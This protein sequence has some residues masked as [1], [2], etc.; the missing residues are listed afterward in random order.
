MEIE[1][2]PK[3]KFKKVYDTV[4]QVLGD[5]IVRDKDCEFPKYHIDYNGIRFHLMI[6]QGSACW[7]TKES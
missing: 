4:F 3:D 5:K 6:G 2:L 1:G 7:I